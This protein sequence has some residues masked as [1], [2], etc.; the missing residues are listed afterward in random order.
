MSKNI[1]PL[2]TAP[3]Q[4]DPA[5]FNAVLDQIERIHQ[6]LAQ[7]AETGYLM[8]NVTVTRTLDA[9]SSGSVDGE[10]VTAVLGT[11]IDDMKA[12]GMVSK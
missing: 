3:D 4:Y 10:S 5:F 1:G 6:T 7:P 9:N 11:L 2:G 12:V 8:T